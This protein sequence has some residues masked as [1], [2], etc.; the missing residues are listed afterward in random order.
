MWRSPD[1]IHGAQATNTPTLPL[2]CTSCSHARPRPVPLSLSSVL[3]IVIQWTK[4]LQRCKRFFRSDSSSKCQPDRPSV[5]SHKY[6]TITSQ[7]RSH[8]RRPDPT[9]SPCG[10]MRPV[11][12]RHCALS[13]HTRAQ[14]AIFCL[15]RI[16]K[17]DCCRAKSY[18]RTKQR[19][20]G[21]VLRTYSYSSTSRSYSTGHVPTWRSV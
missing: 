17:I 8:A 21:W 1:S 14:F 7:P 10:M 3:C 4:H 15:Q 5:H 11:V 16:V 18:P 9:T 2:T 13:Q 19:W 20:L 6:M 12:W